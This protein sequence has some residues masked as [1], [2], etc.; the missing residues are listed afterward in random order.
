MERNA[1]SLE[2]AACRFMLRYAR[3]LAGTQYTGRSTPAG[4][5]AD[6]LI[7][8]NAA[9]TNIKTA[10]CGAEGK[11]TGMGR[12]TEASPACVIDEVAIDSEHDMKDLDR[13]VVHAL[14][15]TCLEE[16]IALAGSVSS[17]VDEGGKFYCKHKEQERYFVQGKPKNRSHKDR[18]AKKTIGHPPEIVV[19]FIELGIAV[20]RT[21]GDVPAAISS[22]EQKLNYFELLSEQVFFEKVMAQIKAKDSISNDGNFGVSSNPPKPTIRTQQGITINTPVLVPLS[23]SSLG[24]LT[25]AAYNNQLDFRERDGLD[26]PAIAGANSVNDGNSHVLMPDSFFP[27]ADLNCEDSL[28]LSLL[29]PLQA[30]MKSYCEVTKCSLEPVLSMPPLA[31]FNLPDDPI[32]NLPQSNSCISSTQSNFDMSDDLI[33]SPAS[34]ERPQCAL[35]PGVALPNISCLANSTC[36]AVSVLATTHQLAPTSAVLVAFTP[37]SSVA[38]S[39]E[40]P[41]STTCCARVDSFRDDLRA[42]PRLNLATEESVSIENFSASYAPD[43]SVK[44]NNANIHRN[45]DVDGSSTCSTFLDPSASTVLKNAQPDDGESPNEVNSN[46]GE[47]KNGNDIHNNNHTNFSVTTCAL[48]VHEDDTFTISAVTGKYTVASRSSDESDDRSG[49]CYD[50]EPSLPPVSEAILLLEDTSSSRLDVV[51]E[52]YVLVS[53][54]ISIA[55]S[56]SGVAVASVSRRHEPDCD[57]ACSTDSVKSTSSGCSGSCSNAN[58][59]DDSSDWSNS[60]VG[61]LGHC[62]DGIFQPII[63]EDRVMSATT[64]SLIRTVSSI[65]SVISG[66]V[67]QPTY[68]TFCAS[69]PSYTDSIQKGNCTFVRSNISSSVASHSNLQMKFQN[70]ESSTVGPSQDCPCNESLD[71]SVRPI[72]TIEVS[73][74][75]S[76][77][78]DDQLRNIIDQNP[79]SVAIDRLASSLRDFGKKETDSGDV[80][81]SISRAEEPQIFNSGEAIQ[82]VISAAPSSTN[83]CNQLTTTKLQTFLSSTPLTFPRS[84]SS[85]TYLNSEEP[86]M[87]SLFSASQSALRRS[88]TSHITIREPCPQTSPASSSSSALQDNQLLPVSPASPFPPDTSPS[89]GFCALSPAHVSAA[90]SRQEAALVSY[91]DVAKSLVTHKRV[92]F[93]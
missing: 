72:P 38:V 16:K 11:I 13:T 64:S 21:L 37:L 8:C 33:N 26:F 39:L 90:L 84:D 68:T 7:T 91:A 4:T 17:N 50:E 58:A 29:S 70:I 48:S 55:S 82:H 6:D 83:T 41:L 30:E 61:G 85:T 66:P 76:T 63:H 74:I 12:T 49:V 53:S 81:S 40:C 19:N 18:K 92:I 23:S 45:S 77:I 36:A 57:S 28:Q 80:E 47:I 44:E 35:P 42:K 71:Q 31:L 9:S 93:N 67:L 14:N 51:S 59:N 65:S 54:S 27:V 3:S 34:M 20:P 73:E 10:L 25:D 69:L 1:F 24:V 60:D 88:L 79:T 46:V 15:S 52:G 78:K 86:A 87:A 2:L 5:D 89:S 22:L 75:V 62:S 43:K 56:D 32:T